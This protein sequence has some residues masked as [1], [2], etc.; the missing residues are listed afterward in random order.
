MAI[1]FTIQTMDNERLIR[2]KSLMKAKS[3]VDVLRRALDSLE[4]QL[5]KQ[6]RLKQWKKAAASVARQSAEVNRDFQKHSL[7][8]QG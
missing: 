6:K 2:L 3:K 5:A 1:P 4:E 8:K 7:I